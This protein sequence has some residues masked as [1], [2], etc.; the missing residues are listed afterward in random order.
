MVSLSSD[1]ERG[2]PG[3]LRLLTWL[4]VTVGAQGV[5][6]G[7]SGKGTSAESDD[8]AWR[9]MSGVSKEVRQVRSAL[10]EGTDRPVVL[11]SPVSLRARAVY[12]ESRWLI[13]AV[14]PT[15][16][17]VNAS[18][19][20]PGMCTGAHLRVLGETRGITTAS[21]SESPTGHAIIADAFLPYQA[22]VY[23]NVR[24]ATE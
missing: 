9:S 7:D 3:T 4:A 15:G 24:G 18:M 11:D 16:K 1:Q 22:H 21:S 10:A 19:S 12:H 14:N 8:P 5:V 6:F 2:T 17:P 20:V 13:I 23:T